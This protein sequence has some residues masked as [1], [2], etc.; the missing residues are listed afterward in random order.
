M[1]WLFGLF[2][3]FCLGLFL[4]AREQARAKRH[5]EVKAQIL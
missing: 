4:W 2:V 1:D 3:E 5:S